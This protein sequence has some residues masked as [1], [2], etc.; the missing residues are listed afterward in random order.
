MG[1]DSSFASITG[2]GILGG[3]YRG[4]RPGFLRKVPASISDA[5]RSVGDFIVCSSQLTPGGSE[6]RSRK[7][8]A[9]DVSRR[10]S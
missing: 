7:A 1:F 3:P 5:E 10:M 4:V 8:V 6:C 2:D 9:A